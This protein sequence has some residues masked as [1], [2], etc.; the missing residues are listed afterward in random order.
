MS[1]EDR[2]ICDACGS[3]LFDTTKPI[4][5]AISWEYCRYCGEKIDKTNNNYEHAMNVVESIIEK[6][7]NIDKI[8]Y[9]LK[10]AYKMYEKE[11]LFSTKKQQIINMNKVIDDINDLS[12][13]KNKEF[14]YNN[15]DYI[16]NQTQ[17]KLENIIEDNEKNIEKNNTKKLEP[18]YG[19]EVKDEKKS[20]LKIL[21]EKTKI[22]NLDLLIIGTSHSA[23]MLDIIYKE[24]EKFDPDLVL[25]EG[26]PGNCFNPG[27]IKKRD[28]GSLDSTNFMIGHKAAQSFGKISGADIEV[29]KGTP[30]NLI[31]DLPPK[32]IDVISEDIAWFE[33]DTNTFRDLVHQKSVQDTERMERLL[34]KRDSKFVIEVYAYIEKHNPNKIAIIAG[35]S[36]V[37]G[38]IDK[39]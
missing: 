36:H 9:Q 35:K 28:D 21:K 33:D 11:F 27:Y 39:I 34:N 22:N 20:N 12:E 37:P 14:I 13:L 26:A 5:V 18:N 29:L 25:V 7:E 15:M 16:S 30:L 19:Y 24:L 38:L 4:Y 3:D 8:Q 1:F 2:F 32:T 17:L 6:S 23:P 10:R 31:N